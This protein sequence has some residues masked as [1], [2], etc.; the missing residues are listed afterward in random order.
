VLGAVALLGPG[1][2]GALSVTVAPG[3]VDLVVPAG[4]S[5]Q[6]AIEV[7]NGGPAPLEV[8]GYLFDWWHEDG[9]QVFPPPGSVERSAALWSSLLPQRLTLEPETRDQL[10]LVV[11]PPPDAE[12]GY[13]AVVWVDASAARDPAAPSTPSVGLAGRIGVLV[14]VRIQGT[15]TDTLAM[16]GIEVLPPTASTPLGIHARVRNDGDVH[17]NPELRAL[18]VDPAGTTH[19]KLE[20]RRNM[21]LPGEEAV[22]E[23]QWGGELQNGAYTALVTVVYGE[24]EAVTA[25]HR[26]TVQNP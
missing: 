24:G 1:V 13:F 15:G 2:A 10:T 9:Q 7:G 6:V 25:E 3:S 26:F 12:G 5:E 23:S 17:Q 8:H 16:N 14:A 4:S 19:A 21:V 11:A 20:G 22:I 18:V